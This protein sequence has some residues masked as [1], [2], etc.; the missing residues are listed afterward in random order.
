[1]SVPDKPRVSVIIPSY[2]P[3]D[4]LWEC[5]GS[6][7]SQTL[8]KEEFEVILVLNGC[9]EPWSGRI[10]NWAKEHPDFPLR[11]IQTGTPGVSNARNLGLSEA[12]GEYIT[13]IDD[14]DYVSPGYLECLLAEAAPGRVVL[15]DA[16]SFVDGR[17]G[18]NEAYVHHRAYGALRHSEGPFS[19]MRVRSFLNGPCMKLIAADVIRSGRFDTSFRNGE[20]SL[21]MFEVSDGIQEIRTAAPGA[22]YYRRFRDGSAYTKHRSLAERL[23]NAARLIGAYT[24]RWGARPGAYDFTFYLSRL[25]ATVKGHL[26]N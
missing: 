9:D 17:E 7:L 3:G 10:R 15:S 26:F 6:L 2:R 13:F 20:D 21:F 4:W 14:D 25:A 23:R 5:L 11:L 8:P 16:L 18:Y 22:V 1:M 19:L 12:R 24:R